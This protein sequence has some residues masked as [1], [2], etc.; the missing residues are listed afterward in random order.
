MYRL[1]TTGQYSAGLPQDCDC[2]GPEITNA[3]GTAVDQA[4]FRIPFMRLAFGFVALF[5]V[6]I[7]IWFLVRRRG[8]RMEPN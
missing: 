7:G 3:D 4:V 5:V 8:A 6:A 2:G 1:E